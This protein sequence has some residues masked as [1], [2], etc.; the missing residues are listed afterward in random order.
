MMLIQILPFIVKAHELRTK[1][2]S[3]LM[4]QLKELKEELQSLRIAQVTGGAPAKLAKI[5]VVRKSIARVLTVINQ[6]T[7]SK[8]SLRYIC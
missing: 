8:V 4:S 6:I 2:K 5:S 1:T 3:E 7:K